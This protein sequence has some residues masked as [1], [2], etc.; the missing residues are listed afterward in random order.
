MPSPL[1]GMNPYLENPELW[2]EFHSRMIV[3]IADALDD[4]LS[5][6]YR[7]AVEK[8]VYLSDDGDNVLIGIPDVSVTAS[9][10]STTQTATLEPITQPISIEIPIAEEV[11]E[12]FL[13][14][15]EVGTGNVITVIEL[16]SPKNKR[17]GEGRSA[18]LQKRLHILVSATHLVEIDLLRGGEALP[19]GAVITSDYRIIIS[20][21]YQR[22]KAELYAFNLQQSIPAIPIPLRSGEDEPVLD[23]Q[24]LLHKIYDRARFKLGID[25]SKACTPKLSKENEA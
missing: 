7:V 3:A 5:E 15:R 10:Q 19:M 8:R 13:E 24:L 22:P 25:Y 20:R 6:D 1:P 16:I 11:Q 17:T 18:Y 4:S 21:S 14:I 2:S 12:R 9:S 23:L